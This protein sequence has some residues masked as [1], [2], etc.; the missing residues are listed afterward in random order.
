M[1]ATIE[2]PA[3][4]ASGAAK[5]IETRTS[6]GPE[7]DSSFL[8]VERRQHDLEQW[9]RCIR[10]LAALRDL[11]DDWDGEGARAPVIENVVRAIQ[12]I[13]LLR[14]TVPTLPVPCAAAGVSG[15]VLLF[16]RTRGYSL[17]AEII[18]PH[19]FEW[20]QM[21]PDGAAQHWTD[22]GELTSVVKLFRLPEIW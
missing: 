21:E 6:P 13:E 19:R 15:D 2:T 7:K 11:E 16:W 22:G 8:K 18:Q 5:Q 17:Q 3:K 10:S 4:N 12:F 14:G 1:I 20:M 9:D